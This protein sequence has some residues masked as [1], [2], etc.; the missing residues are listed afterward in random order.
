MK[1][2]QDKTTKTS[3]QP[4][5]SHVVAWWFTFKQLS[6]LSVSQDNQEKYPRKH[7]DKF[8][9][10]FQ[11]CFVHSGYL[12][13]TK[14]KMSHEN[15]SFTNWNWNWVH[16]KNRNAGTL[17]NLWARLTYALVSAPSS[18]CWQGLKFLKD[19]WSKFLFCQ[20]SASCRNSTDAEW[21]DKHR[22]RSLQYKKGRS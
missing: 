20:N 9:P 21:I 13:A 4:M 17:D 10:I 19:G 11:V 16:F 15:P 7:L 5:L 12:S 2:R 3:S 6:H 8:L 22:D 14:N 1:K 18:F